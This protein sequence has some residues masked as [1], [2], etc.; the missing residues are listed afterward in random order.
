MQGSKKTSIDTFEEYC[1]KER[2][3]YKNILFDRKED[4]FAVYNPEQSLALIDISGEEKN[5][6]SKS[7]TCQAN[8]AILFA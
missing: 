3:L 6:W 4:P 8:I 1:N 2:F 7:R 5:L